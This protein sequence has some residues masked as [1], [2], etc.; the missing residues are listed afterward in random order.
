MQD[1][2]KSDSWKQKK[3]SYTHTESFTDSI[4]ML[5]EKYNNSKY[6]KQTK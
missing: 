1:L 4:T 6:S 5:K 2:N 3:T